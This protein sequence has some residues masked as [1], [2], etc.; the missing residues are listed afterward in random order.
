MPAGSDAR[1]DGEV[2]RREGPAVGAG[3]DSSRHAHM[4]STLARL[5]TPRGS[6]TTALAA[7]IAAC[8]SVERVHTTEPDFTAAP[9]Q[10]SAAAGGL[11]QRLTI[12]ATSLRPGDVLELRSTIVNDGGAES[13]AATTRACGLDVDAPSGLRVPDLRLR[14]GA[15]SMSGSLAPGESRIEHEQIAIGDR[16]GVH[17][18]RVRHLLEP[19]LWV[20]IDVEVR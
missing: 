7:A 17:T 4:L 16:P 1:A 9:R 8:G 12:S 11:T 5:I 10:V 19:E 20:S 15:Y 13:I 3:P 6:A 18:L 2:F 14:C